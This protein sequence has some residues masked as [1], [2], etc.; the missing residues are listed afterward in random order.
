MQKKCW[1]CQ[2]WN[3]LKIWNRSRAYERSSGVLRSSVVVASSIL[4]LSFFCLWSYGTALFFLA[5]FAASCF[6]DVARLAANLLQDI[7][8]VAITGMT[9]ST[10]QIKFDDWHAHIH[11]LYMACTCD[12]YT[13]VAVWFILAK[14]Q[15]SIF[16]GCVIMGHM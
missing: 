3:F 10:T 6:H 1:K 4:D 13:C 7:N 14:N 11:V 15:P 8:S 5:F 12:K 9:Y 16:S 2:F